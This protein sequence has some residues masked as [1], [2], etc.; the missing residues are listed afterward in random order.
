MYFI[1]QGIVP[2]KIARDT[3]SVGTQWIEVSW[4]TDTW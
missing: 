3:E 1:K 4:Y 2:I